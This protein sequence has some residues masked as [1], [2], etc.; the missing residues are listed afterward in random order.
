MS[1]YT[2]AF[3]SIYDGTLFGKWPTA[4]VWASLLPLID[5][6]GEIRMSY[7]AIAARTGWPMD[8]LKQGISELM[9]PDPES[10]STAEEGRRLVLLDPARSWGWRAVNH[11]VYREKARLRAKNQREVESGKNRERM[12]DRRGPPVTAADP[13]SDTAQR[14]S[15]TTQTQTQSSATRAPLPAGEMAIALR[16]LGV[17]VKSTDKVLQGWLR[18]GFTTQQA[19]EAVGIARIRKPHPQRIPGNYLDPILRQPQRAPPSQVDRITW[20]PPPDDDENCR[21]PN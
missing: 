15:D 18:D 20:R 11:A 7:E 3:S 4:A 21:V 8:L 12:G 5:Q 9:K 14:N 2:P 1:G 6:H 10:Q 16:D 17:D 13:L 19:V